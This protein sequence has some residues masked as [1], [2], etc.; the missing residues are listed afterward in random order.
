VAAVIRVADFLTP[1]PPID[2][3]FKYDVARLSQENLS[4]FQLRRS[5][6]FA[7]MLERES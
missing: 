2:L 5:Y 1:A 6:D 7:Y 3:E 4:V